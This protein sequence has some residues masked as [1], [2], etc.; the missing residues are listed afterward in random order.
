MLE[1]N[2]PYDGGKRILNYRVEKR[3]TQSERWVRVTKELISEPKYT[4][5]DL[6]EGNEYEFRVFAQNSIGYSPPSVPSKAV[7]C[8]DPINPPSMPINISVVDIRKKEVTVQWGLPRHDGGAK[9][10]GYIVE[11]NKVGTDSW[12]TWCTAE[13][14][15][16]VFNLSALKS[17]LIFRR[18]VRANLPFQIWLNHLN[19]MSELKR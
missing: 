2:K 16:L 5:K 13:V 6:L 11:T 8:S 18:R 1:W 17:N 19:I 7:I 4:V 3:E 14:S 12:K 9:I 15:F 10:D